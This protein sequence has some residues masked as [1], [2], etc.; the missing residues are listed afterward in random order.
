MGQKTHPYG[1]RLGII[2]GWKSRWFADRNF[3]DLLQEDLLIRRY[4]NKRLEHAGVA[5]IQ[6]LR[7]LKKVTIDI[8]TAK[9]G[10][11]IGRKGAEVDKLKEELQMLSGKEIL[12]NI[13]EVKKPE[14]SASLVAQS[15]AQQLV[16]RVSFRRAMKKAVAAAMKSGAEGIK[17]VCGG[18]LGGAEIARSEKYHQ[19]RVPLHTL[20]ADI[21]YATAT[22]HT[23]Y[24]CI[25]VKV[26]ICRGEIVE[27][28][29]A[30][31]QLLGETL[32]EKEEKPRAR[33]QKPRGKRPGG[34]D[35][36]PSSGRKPSAKAMDKSKRRGRPDERHGERGNRPGG[37][38]G[39]DRHQGK[40]ER[41]RQEGQKPK[42]SKDASGKAGDAPDKEKK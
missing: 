32:P 25:G 17:V 15:I 14:L 11:V 20:R 36:R 40:G 38:G 8:H 37:S 28:E 7:A 35:R 4:T 42:P 23:T 9:P 21:D 33:G 2:K 6:I 18:R 30:H 34:E 31:A 27:K 3:A 19:G 24:G 22:A 13:I 41:P 10:I 26:W 39:R 5:D 16:G 29:K 12:L 1:L